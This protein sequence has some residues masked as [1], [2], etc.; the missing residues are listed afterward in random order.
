MHGMRLSANPQPGHASH[1]AC[2][3]ACGLYMYMYNCICTTLFKIILGQL[4]SLLHK[5]E[6]RD[7]LLG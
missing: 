4:R 2:P 1:M 6:N 7:K 5:A 3:V